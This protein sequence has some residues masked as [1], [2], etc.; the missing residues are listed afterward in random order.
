MLE[1]TYT[2]RA[3]VQAPKPAKAPVAPPAAAKTAQREDLSLESTLTARARVLPSSHM[4][5]QDPAAS[6]AAQPRR[7][8]LSTNELHKL[9]M[10]I[11]AQREGAGL[12]QDSKDAPSK[13]NK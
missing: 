3:R 13:A 6:E 2:L 9:S 10:Q 8:R 5:A 12:N 4:K 7:K 11:K 1:S